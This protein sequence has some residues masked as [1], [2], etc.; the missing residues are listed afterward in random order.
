MSIVR[1]LLGYAPAVVLPRIVSLILVLILTRLISKQEYGLFVLVMTIAEM[2]DGIVNNW[3][4][5]ALARFA[6]ARGGDFGRETVR[7]LWIYCITLIP[8]FAIAIAAGVATQSEGR[9]Q[10]VAAIMIYLISTG[11]L[12]F[13]STVMSVQADRNG[14]VAMEAVKAL[15][16]LVLGVGAAF[17]SGSY[18][19][20]TLVYALVTAA[21]GAWGVLRST[22]PL[23][24]AAGAL[25]PMPKFLGYGLPIIAASIVAVTASS[26]D[27]VFLNQ[28]VG[29]EAVALYAAGVLLAR[30]PMDFLFSLAG[31]RVF[32]LMM[33]DYERGGVAQARRRMSEL[34]SGVAFM[35]LPAAAGILLVAEPMSRLLLAPDYADAA[36]AILPP[37]LAAALFAGFKTFVLEQVY[38]MRKRNGLNGLA[39][40]PAALV[41]LAAMAAMVPKWGVWGCA[42]AY[43]IQNAVLF[44]TNYVMVQRLMPFPV[45][46]G[47]VGRTTAATA[48][49]AGVLLALGGPLAALPNALHLAA[50]II[51]GVGVYAG[52]AL[53]LRPSPVEELLPARF[54]RSAS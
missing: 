51:V 3:V 2:I 17:A 33:E 52:A 5:I 27:R 39:T 4:R 37:A 18:F 12:R 41:G 35:T 48:I 47:D 11:I 1:S 40:L 34:I 19:A 26:S 6:S 29:P 15:G 25:E 7:S 46:W 44:A 28:M 13:P 49:M 21:V 23:D 50:A 53:V 42:V 10:F 43:L 31:V 32:P 8:S 36:V 45:P 9:I 16:V 24:L 14:I 38:H 22:R 20:Q 54:R 30:Q